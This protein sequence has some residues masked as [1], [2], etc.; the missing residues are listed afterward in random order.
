M[1][2]GREKERDMLERALR[3]ENSEFVAV[4]G[5]RRIG[6]T[7]L[8]R[9]TFHSRFTFQ[10]SGIANANTQI[11]QERFRQSL[12]E[13]GHVKCPVLRTWFQA[14]DELKELL[15]ASPANKKILFIDEMPWMDKP[16]ANFLPALENFWNAW[17]SDRKDVLLII[18]GSATSWMLKNMIHARGGLHNRVTM[19]IHLNPFTLAE[20]EKMAVNLG[21]EVS[22]Y[23]L[24][25]YYM[26]LGGVPFY[27]TFL[28][29]GLSVAQNMDALFFLSNANLEGE[30]QDL[31]SSL[32]SKE[33]PYIQIVSALGKK[34][35]GMN[36]EEI[37]AE[38]GIATSGTL[39][40]Y[41]EEL[42]Q[43][44]FLRKYHLPGKNIRDAIY[45]LID[46]YTLFYFRFI[47]DNTAQDPHFWTSSVDTSRFR[48]WQGL[49]FELVC[50]QHVD[51]IRNALQISGMQSAVYAW[52]AS[53][54]SK[55]GGAQI[56][57]VIDRKDGV[58]NLCEMKYAADKYAIT[59]KDNTALMQK[60]EAFLQQM[61]R[62]KACHITMVTTF[63]LVHNAYWNNV[64]SEITLND[65]FKELR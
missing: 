30:F 18:C 57:L 47:R 64:Q 65:L 49:A 58:I 45:Q 55:T 27:W 42:Q 60:K 6:K 24:L 33:A 34:R 53:A 39:T 14:F 26:A 8:I 62:R 21:L 4:Y 63:G 19:R 2:V 11:Q 54:T 20:C 13:A 56:D 43:C 41:L 38:T 28:Q 51:N 3:S 52:Q 9:E 31:Y 22:R 29:R 32:F 16:N 46:N 59:A 1:M 37:A 44:G 15:K 25:Q 50:L 36:R 61:P 10:H 12:I 35:M 5:R 48:T 7:Y 17:A 40:K 23:Q